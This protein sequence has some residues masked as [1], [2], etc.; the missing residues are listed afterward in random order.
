MKAMINFPEV[1]ANSI[2]G[3]NYSGMHDSAVAIVGPDGTPIFACALERLT[4]V[5][6]DGRPPFV[7]LENL[8]WD[9]IAKVAIST[10]Q[11]FVFPSN[12]ESKL[13]RVRLPSVRNQGLSHEPAFY[14]FLKSIPVEKEFV[15]HQMA[16]AASAFWASGFEKALCLTYD[17]GMSNSPWFGGLYLADRRHGLR[18]LDQ[19][20]A[21]HY[22]TVPSL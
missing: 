6:Q 9:R 13:L 7:L 22:A 15:C 12:G 18:V 11:S 1:P 4:R 8:P 14:D 10:N 20:S 5:K 17:G 16:H 3:L 19:F 21:R 2:L